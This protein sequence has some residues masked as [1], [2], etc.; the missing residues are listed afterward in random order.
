MLLRIHRIIWY[1]LYVCWKS[2]RRRGF[3]TQMQFGKF[4]YI[5]RAMAQGIIIRVSSQIAVYL[6][7]AMI[8]AVFIL[9]SNL[10]KMCVYSMRYSPYIIDDGPCLEMQISNH[11]HF[12]KFQ[13]NIRSET[14]WNPNRIYLFFIYLLN[15]YRHRLTLRV[16][17]DK[18][19]LVSKSKY[20]YFRSK[21]EFYFQ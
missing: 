11:K 8:L 19:W 21:K 4:Y 7:A 1:Y 15:F 13:I 20:M 5:L 10:K 17:F 16:E 2:T 9:N 14:T 3:N 6:C 12:K 18:R